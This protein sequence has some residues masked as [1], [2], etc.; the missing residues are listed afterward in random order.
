MFF[1]L[2]KLPKWYHIAQSI[3]I[4]IFFV[5]Y[6]GSRCQ[7]EIDKCNS[8]NL[9]GKESCIRKNRTSVCLCNKGYTG[10]KCEINIDDCVGVSCNHGKCVDGIDDYHCSCEKRWEGSNCTIPVSI[11]ILV[12]ITLIRLIPSRKEIARLVLPFFNPFLHSV[13]F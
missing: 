5:G 12:T 11:M 2:F 13:P 1:T 8:C 9:F 4:L 7:F 6:T 10:E 3:M